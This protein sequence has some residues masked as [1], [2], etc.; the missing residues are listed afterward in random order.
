MGNAW[1][2]CCFVRNNEAGECN[3]TEIKLQFEFSQ[4]KWRV[5]SLLTWVVIN[6]C[7]EKRTKSVKKTWFLWWNINRRKPTIRLFFVYAFRYD[8][9][10]LHSLGK[11]NY[12]TIPASSSNCILSFWMFFVCFLFVFTWRGICSI[13]LLI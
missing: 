1:H 13:F 10:L 5:F 2:I 11:N 3:S 8:G 4:K 6:L 12:K 7:A 9:R